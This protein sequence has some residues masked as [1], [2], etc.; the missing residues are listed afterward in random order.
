MISP[1]CVESRRANSK[2]RY[3]RTIDIAHITRARLR[4]AVR[5]PVDVMFSRQSIVLIRFAWPGVISGT[6]VTLPSSRRADGPRSQRQEIQKEPILT[7]RRRQVLEIRKADGN[8]FHGDGG[9]GDVSPLRRRRF[10]CDKGP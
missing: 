1:T 6:C 8:R 10:I 2:P 9:L 4:L 5:Q 3:F 7:S